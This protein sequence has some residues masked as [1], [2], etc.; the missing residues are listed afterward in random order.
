MRLGIVLKKYRAMQEVTVRDLAQD[1]GV[2]A[3]TMCRIENGMDC[4][5]TTL[6]KIFNWLTAVAS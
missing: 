6:M 1:V 3:A 5:S 4:D 2:S